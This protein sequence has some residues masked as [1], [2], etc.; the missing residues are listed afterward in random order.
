MSIRLV[1]QYWLPRFS[2]DDYVAVRFLT[3]DAIEAFAPIEFSVVSPPP[4][5]GNKN[6]KTASLPIADAEVSSSSVAVANV[7][8][9]KRRDSEQSIESTSSASNQTDGRNTSSSL[10]SRSLSQSPSPR[11]HSSTPPSEIEEDSTTDEQSQEKQYSCHRIHILFQRL[12]NED[13]NLFQY[14]V[15]YRSGSSTFGIIDWS[16]IKGIAPTEESKR[17]DKVRVLHVSATDLRN[18]GHYFG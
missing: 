7:L 15:K 17:E 16:E 9:Q 18:R 12:K 8:G 1:Q 14:R 13:I 6:D 2:N 4:I 5:S 11:S 3:Q 10:S